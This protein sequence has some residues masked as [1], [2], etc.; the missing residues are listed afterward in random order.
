MFNVN[1]S[2]SYSLSVAH[3]SSSLYF[4]KVQTRVIL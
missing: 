3:M 4:A 1:L 2:G